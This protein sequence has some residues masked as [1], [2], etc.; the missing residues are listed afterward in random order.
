MATAEHWSRAEVEALVT[1]YLHMLT[2]ELAG[3]QYNK[4]AHRRALARKLN[5]RSDGSIERKHQNVSAV[6]RDLNCFYI[7]GYKPLSNYQSLL[8]D[9][10]L[11]R[12]A[13]NPTF[14]R[15]ATSA[16]EQPAVAPLA[17]D[18]SRLVE[19]PPELRTGRD[20]AE[21]VARR[22]AAR[23]D[24]VA[25]ESQNRSLGL[26]GEEFVLAYEHHRLYA[27]GK[28]KLADRVEHVSQTKG[29]GLG[30]DILSYDEVT[31]RERFIEVKTTAFGKETPFYISRNEVALSAE[32]PDQFRLYRVFEFRRQPR[33]F[34]L[35]GKV[36]NR[37]VLDPVTYIARFG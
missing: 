23:R 19:D 21:Y 5:N 29:D 12:I 25:L 37:C 30:Y 13:S 24:F 36:E 7:P 9:I 28:P 8:F 18:F 33:F 26:A 4:T 34:V 10:V 3:Q 27:A 15:I 14:E 1:D 32:V 31:G 17:P 20:R 22:V 11:E 6:L 16:A 2:Q 35:P